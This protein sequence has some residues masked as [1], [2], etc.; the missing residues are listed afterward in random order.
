MSFLYP[1]GLLGLI[2]VPILIIIYI[3]KNKHT[4]QIVSSNYL[5]HL[6]EKFLKNKKPISMI[7]G[8]IS[9]IL[10]LL[11]VIVIS[12]LL[13]HPV[14]TL[15]NTAKEYCFI[16]DGSGSMN[17]VYNGKTRLELGKDEITNIINDS[18]DGSKYT[19]VFASDTTRV[20][21]EKLGNKE[22]A[23]E[24]L[25]SLTCSGV[26]ANYN[27]GLQYVQEYFNDNSS[28]ITYLITDEN[29]QTSNIELIN[30][31]NNEENC[32]ILDVNYEY[33]NRKLQISGTIVSYTSDKNVILQIY[34]DESLIKEENISLKKLENFDFKYESSKT[35]FVSL[36]VEIV[37]EDSLSL[38]DS[39]II[40]NIE[41]E[42]QFKTLLVSD[43]PFYLESIISTIGT[44]TVEVVSREEYTSLMRGYSLY[45]FEI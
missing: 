44:T 33:V 7:S 28:L 14:I 45:I 15:P 34:I 4:E 22:K 16:L 17:T 1:L 8:I 20:I 9:L 24:M 37:S 12:L 18:T 43:R 6:S 27:V 39:K 10:Q 21:Y 31:A 40:Y 19:L 11:A 32:G 3:I 13:A 26:T 35:E 25:E 2:G 38:D 42:H 29:Y 5:W 30:V 41:K 36:R 23:C